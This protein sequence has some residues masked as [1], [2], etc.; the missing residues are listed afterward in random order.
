MN[1]AEVVAQI[2]DCLC[3][4]FNAEQLQ[5]HFSYALSNCSEGMKGEFWF[6]VL[7]CHME[8]KKLP[9]DKFDRVHPLDRIE[10]SFTDRK[11][12]GNVRL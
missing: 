5:Q 6:E 8:T 10:S 1:K 12:W 9:K 2:R 4:G 7:M 11:F 3:R